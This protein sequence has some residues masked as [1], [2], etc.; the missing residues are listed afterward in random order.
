MTMTNE[1]ILTIA[2]VENLF[3]MMYG[4]KKTFNRLTRSELT[5]ELTRLCADWN[6]GYKGFCYLEKRCITSKISN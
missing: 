4:D 5:K 2:K 6:V 1:T 3:G